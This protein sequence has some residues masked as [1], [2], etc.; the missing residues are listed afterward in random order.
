MRTITV[1]SAA[2]VLDLLEVLSS[3]P[4]PL[5]LSDLAYRLAI[6]K[7]SLFALLSTLISKGYAEENAD[8]FQLAERF[9]IGG[10]IGGDTGNL[11]RIARAAMA[12]LASQTGESAFL[13]VMTAQK[14][15][16]YLV[17][18]LSPN[19]IR[20]DTDLEH[21][22]SGYSTSIGLIL[23]G[24]LP[25]AELD[26]Y[27]ASTRFEA[28]TP[29]TV[30]DPHEIRQLIEQ[31]RSQGYARTVDSNF[32]GVAG[33]STAV[34]GPDGRALAGLALI[35]PTARFTASLDSHIEAVTAAA[36]R[37]G[38]TLTGRR[39]S[40]ADRSHRYRMTA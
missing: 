10:W 6:P 38:T 35:G 40:E 12:E 1:K 32:E 28:K 31:A 34:R 19:H 16:Q 29:K 8:G 37:I 22:R 3:T 27:L 24:D 9:R 36:D 17:K 7:S 15:V 14:E 5:G 2:R 21:P 30:T 11:V 4:R 26:Q 39:Q 20:Y 25:D 33:V 18:A 23:L 13:A